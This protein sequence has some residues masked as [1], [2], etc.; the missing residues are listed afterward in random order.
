[1]TQWAMW[2][3]W[4]EGSRP[5]ET[6]C[7]LPVLTISIFTTRVALAVASLL[8][9]PLRKHV[10]GDCKPGANQRHHQGRAD[11]IRCGDHQH[12]ADHRQPRPLPFA[13]DEIA[14]TD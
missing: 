6:R 1:M 8:V 4:C 7:R 3:Q 12:A 14:D 10:N 13:I 5:V 9:A 11:E 2:P